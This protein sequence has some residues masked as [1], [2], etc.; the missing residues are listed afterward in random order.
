M[1]HAKLALELAGEQLGQLC[2]ETPDLV[3]TQGRADPVAGADAASPARVGERHVGHIAEALDVPKAP[4]VEGLYLFGVHASPA[5]LRPARVVLQDQVLG[6]AGYIAGQGHVAE[7][8]DEQAAA[9]GEDALD[10]CDSSVRVEPP[11][12]LTCAHEV[13]AGV[14]LAGGLGATLDE[15]SGQLAL[16]GGS[17]CDLEKLGGDVDAGDLEPAGGEAQSERPGAR[18]Q[19]EGAVTCADP[20]VAYQA[21][22]EALREARAM[23]FVVDGGAAKVDDSALVVDGSSTLAHRGESSASSSNLCGVLPARNG[24]QPPFPPVLA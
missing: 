11:P 10:L 21:V 18:A 24:E 17:A 16:D 15:V 19:I 14:V 5:R 12:A 23:A 1:R 22:E 20:A 6:A 7:V 13:E 2:V 9:W 3:G 4:A 8:T